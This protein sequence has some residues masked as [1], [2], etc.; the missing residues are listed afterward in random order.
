MERGVFDRR[1]TIQPG[2]VC[3]GAPA[4][5]REMGFPDTGDRYI[6]TRA[7]NCNPWDLLR[8]EDTKSSTC[9]PAGEFSKDE[10]QKWET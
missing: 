1:G 3:A 8:G 5:S 6:D 9:T 10:Q 2:D 7:G 4:G